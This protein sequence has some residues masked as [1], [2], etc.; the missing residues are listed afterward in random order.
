MVLVDRCGAERARSSE[1]DLDLH[2]LSA[3][4]HFVTVLETENVILDPKLNSGQRETL[5]CG[6]THDGRQTSSEGSSRS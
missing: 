4:P 2:H 6:P 5:F 1:T 3:F